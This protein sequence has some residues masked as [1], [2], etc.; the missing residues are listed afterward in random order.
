M[1]SSSL[2]PKSQVQT[3]SQPPEDDDKDEEMLD[4]DQ[5]EQEDEPR[6]Q[7]ES[8]SQSTTHQDPRPP[9]ENRKDK[10]LNTFLNSM[11]KYAPI[12]YIPGDT[13]TDDRF[14]TQ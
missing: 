12:V 7:P 3:V 8:L 13:S 4:A 5:E 14:P 1:S 6:E 9:R 11:D 10:D 2:S